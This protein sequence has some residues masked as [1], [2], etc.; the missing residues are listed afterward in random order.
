MPQVSVV[1][2]CFAQAHFLS[3]AIESVLTQTC[4]DHEIIVID[5]GSPDDVREVVGRHP[6]V[7]CLS[8]SNE[9]LSAA[10]NRGMRESTGDFIVFLDADDRLLPHALA[11]GLAAFA[12]RPN[13]AFVW[14]YRR[15]IDLAGQPLGDYPDSLHAFGRARY[16]D[17]LRENIIGPPVVVMFRRAAVEQAGGF[18]TEQ[19]CCEDYELY[20]RLVRRHETWGHQQV[21]AE[22]RIHDANMSR[23][24]PAMLAG[25]L[26]AL[27]RQ[28]PF[29]ESV[30]ELRRAVRIGRRV[31]HERQ[32][33]G[34]RLLAVRQSFRSG[35]WSQ[36]LRSGAMLLLE[37]PRVVVPAV[38]RWMGRTLSGR[39][40]RQPEC[41]AVP[42]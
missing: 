30:P 2:P 37:Y 5:D 10:R 34:P 14:G 36:A 17:L 32:E 11:A 33:G 41:R 20:L 19:H 21:I 4:T 26:M 29:T 27:D 42:E 7:R 16:I 40:R 13:C 23:N 31:A 24:H 39:P 1:I 8:Q 38:L 15:L 18:L 12:S 22:Y 25:N 9:G 6:G 35:Y 28:A 3:D